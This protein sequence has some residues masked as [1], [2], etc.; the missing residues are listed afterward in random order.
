MDVADDLCRGKH[1]RKLSMRAQ[2]VSHVHRCEG[3]YR[4]TDAFFFYGL[5]AIVV[6]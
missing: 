1:Q 6:A 4:T 5:V 3:D 2:N